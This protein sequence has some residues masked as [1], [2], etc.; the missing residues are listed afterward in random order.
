MNA[1]P[2]VVVPSSPSSPGLTGDRHQRV[3]IARLS[4][5]ACGPPLSRGMTAEWLL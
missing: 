3:V 5:P 1:S 4:A 2:A